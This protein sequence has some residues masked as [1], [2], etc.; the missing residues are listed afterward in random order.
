M[1]EN[2]PLSVVVLSCGRLGVE[3]AN[4]LRAL[5]CL[6]EVAVITTP[7]RMKQR[8][9]VGKIKH[10]YRM[11]GPPGFIEWIG[12]KL[13]RLVRPSVSDGAGASPDLAEGVTHLRFD[14]F[15]APECIDAL[16]KMHPD[17]GVVAGTYI[18]QESVF[19][20]PR[21]GSIN[22]HSGKV[23]DYRGAAPAFWELYH[24]ETEVGIT[25]HRVSARVDEG[26]VVLEGVFPLDPAP[27]GDP[28]AYVESYRAEVL[29]PNGIRLMVSAVQQIADG[30]AVFKPQDA[31]AGRTHRSPTYGAVKELRRRVRKRRR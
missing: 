29:Q 27:S 5:P 8:S 3:L 14:D 1:P 19:A 7:Y 30:S 9:F 16:K 4:Q 18:L 23:P 17:L 21:L 26:A 31:G 22:L 11:K 13:G 6:S 20:I 2:R 28:L 25:I 10:L 24:G 12:T 15:H